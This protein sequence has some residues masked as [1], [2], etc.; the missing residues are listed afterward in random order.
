MGPVSMIF[1]GVVV[2]SAALVV[3]IIAFFKLSKLIKSNSSVAQAAS[4]L[5]RANIVG[6][7]IALVALLLNIYALTIMYPLVL[8]AVQSGDYSNLLGSETMLSPN[9][10]PN[11]T[12]G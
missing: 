5:K 2:S 8:E 7:V 9:N 6:F 4:R 10:A 11:S 12:W 3:E 1:G